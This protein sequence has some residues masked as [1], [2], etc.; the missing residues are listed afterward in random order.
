M[1]TKVIHGTIALWTVVCLACWIY[2]I[3]GAG[4]ITGAP[5]VATA[6]TGFMMSLTLWTFIWFL[7]TLGLK[8]IDLLV[9]LFT[10]E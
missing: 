9:F 7:P 2:E 1:I 10:I 6:V 8:S 3:S 4:L 5:S